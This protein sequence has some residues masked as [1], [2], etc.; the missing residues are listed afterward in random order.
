MGTRRI[1]P[2]MTGTETRHNRDESR[3]EGWVDGALAGFAAYELD[4]PRI[5]FTHTEVDDAY[6]GTGVGSA[7]ARGALDNVREQGNLRVV[8]R[9]AFITSWIDQHP[10]YQ[11][12]VH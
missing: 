12:L 5:V 8:S 2:H 6:E 10:D 9:C 1:L 4:G 11:D 7:I 3:Y